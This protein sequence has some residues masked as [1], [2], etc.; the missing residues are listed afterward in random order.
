MRIRYHWSIDRKS[1]YQISQV[2]FVAASLVRFVTLLH[3]VP[4][5]R[6]QLTITARGSGVRPRGEKTRQSN[7]EEIPQRAHA[8]PHS[9]LRVCTHTHT[10]TRIAS[11]R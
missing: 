4:T 7:A 6:E 11:V 9:A 2:I 10:H 5:V 3:L 1:I 8:E